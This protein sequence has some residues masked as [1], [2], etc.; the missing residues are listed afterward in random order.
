MQALVRTVVDV[1]WAGICAGAEQKA[2]RQDAGGSH[3]VVRNQ[4]EK[5]G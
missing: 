5:S 3:C 2:A 1:D 4:G